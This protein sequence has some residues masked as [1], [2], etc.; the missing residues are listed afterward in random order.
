MKP[1]IKT[2]LVVSLGFLFLV[3]LLFGVLGIFYINKISYNSDNIIKNNYETLVF[4]NNMLRSLE[5]LPG[6]KKAY[7][8]FEENLVKQEHNITEP[9][10]KQATEALR[11][12]YN[13][14]KRK[15]N[16]FLTITTSNS[17]TRNKKDVIQY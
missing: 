17:I 14:L 13:E 2:K 11:K 5:E 6:N 3:I 7:E 4:S 8:T 16:E 15:Y 12:N 10:E 9:G 1:N